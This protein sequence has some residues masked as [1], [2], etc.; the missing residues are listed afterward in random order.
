MTRVRRC[1]IQCDQIVVT[2]W[3][4]DCLKF[5]LVTTSLTKVTQ[6]LGDFLGYFDNITLLVKTALASFGAT[7]ENLGYFLLQT[8]VSLDDGYRASGLSSNDTFIELQDG[9]FKY[10]DHKQICAEPTRVYQ[11]TF[12]NTRNFR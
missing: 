6:I 9:E 11:N 2:F 4:G 3:F 10:H 5:F 7:F 8:L 1:I 12:I